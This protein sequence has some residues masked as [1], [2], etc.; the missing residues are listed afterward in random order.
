[1]LQ[2]RSETIKRIHI[3][4][5][6]FDCLT[7][8]QQGYADNGIYVIMPTG[9][10]PTD[11]W[12]DM[13]NG[14]WTVIQR[15][16]DGSEDFYRDWEDYKTGFG[17]KSGEYWLGNENIY[18]LTT[19]NTSLHIYMETFEAD[20]VNPFSAVAEYSRFKVNDENDKYRLSVGGYN[21]T[22][23]DSFSPHDG[24]QFTTKDSDNDLFRKNCA[25]LF[26]GGW[27][28]SS[29]HL[30]H[31][32]GVYLDTNFGRGIN[33]EGCWGLYYSLKTTVMKIKRNTFN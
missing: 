24:N 32:N 22:C 11:V 4:P 31:L 21:G 20:N 19:Q 7:L 33:W 15:R 16:Q 6:P 27:W 25:V 12:C 30:V 14:G 2:Q 26:G 17:D 10:T 8:Y 1:M 29:C 13:T 23:V 9:I 18:Y 28:Y 5:E 3:Q